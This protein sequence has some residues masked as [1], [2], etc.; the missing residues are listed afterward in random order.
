MI[1]F[2]Y[3][4]HYDLTPDFKILTTA[5][6]PDHKFDSTI[7]L[8][9][10]RGH[11]LVYQV[12]DK[13]GVPDLAQRAMRNIMDTFYDHFMSLSGFSNVVKLVFE[14]T[15]PTDRKLRSWLVHRCA[16]VYA[17]GF[18]SKKV[19]E[20]LWKYEPVAWG[21]ARRMCN[22]CAKEMPQYDDDRDYRFNR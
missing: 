21:V 15:G 22:G 19:E 12:A 1:K 18:L 17:M 8:G 7:G 13:Y 6:Q 4:G 20:A 9:C 11:I 3:K 5:S 14:E 2:L 10:L 16:R